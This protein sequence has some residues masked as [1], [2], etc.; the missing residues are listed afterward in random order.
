MQNI[1]YVIF[2]ARS[3]SIY[4]FIDFRSIEYIIT[5]TWKTQNNI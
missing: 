3:Y 5:T 4:L 1:Q 2:Y